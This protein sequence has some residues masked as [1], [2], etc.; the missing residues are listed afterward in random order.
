MLQEQGGGG[1]LTQVQHELLRSG[2]VE[3]GETAERLT[4]MLSGLL[5][6]LAPL[7]TAWV[8]TAGTTYQSIQNALADNM[9]VLYG[10]LTSIAVDMGIS[11][12][13]FQLTDEEIATDLSAQGF[14]EEG[15][16]TR[17]LGQGSDV[18]QAVE[19]GA[20]NSA[21]TEAMNSQ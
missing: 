15:D 17:L 9:K 8:G 1:N 11:A 16:L 4:N 7:S 20:S 12:D 2:G 18:Q 5:E 10:A 3:A 14:M 13:Q 19:S 21:I 6:E